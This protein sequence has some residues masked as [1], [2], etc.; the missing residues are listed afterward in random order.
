MK[1][2]KNT[3]YWVTSITCYRGAKK[4]VWERQDE[5]Q[6]A[7]YE[8]KDWSI[9]GS[10]EIFYTFKTKK[11]MEHRETYLIPICEV[12]NIVK[13]QCIP[14]DITKE[15]EFILENSRIMNNDMHYFIKIHHNGTKIGFIDLDTMKI[16]DDNYFFKQGIDNN[17][18]IF[19]K[20]K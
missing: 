15:C 5:P 20:G 7:W 19:K 11:A 17:F 2:L 6:I 12:V 3:H 14:M 10:D 4:P 8:G 9:I 1:L 13:K 16:F 18:N